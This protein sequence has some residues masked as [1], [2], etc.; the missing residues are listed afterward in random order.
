M[1]II[2]GFAGNKIGET[3]GKR[4][5]IFGGIVLIGLAGKTF[6]QN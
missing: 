6:F 2:G 5:E 4:A 1:A 3:F